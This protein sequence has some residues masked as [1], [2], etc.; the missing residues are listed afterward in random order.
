MMMTKFRNILISALAAVACVA[1]LSSDL[2]RTGGTNSRV[3]I[4]VAA[5]SLPNADT[6]VSATPRS[7]AQFL[8]QSVAAAGLIVL[9]SS[10][11]SV[12][13]SSAAAAD[14]TENKL[15]NLSD[16]DLKEIV[17]KDVVDHKFLTNGKLTRTIYDESATF[18][19]EIDTYTMD[20]W[21]VGT[22]KLFVGDKSRVDLVGDIDVTRD[23]VEFRFDEDLMFNIPF[24][25][26]VT[27][28]GKVVLQ[29]SPDTGLITSYQEFW[30]QDVASVLKSAKF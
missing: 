1:L 14:V 24:K 16:A 13:S 9:G 3:N 28:T 17:R 22:Q 5:W 10:T 18:T 23:R 7:R 29:R 27:L 11:I 15:V 20:K 21:I 25:P 6:I 19:D 2:S 12:A 26:V 8:Q 4:F 30:D